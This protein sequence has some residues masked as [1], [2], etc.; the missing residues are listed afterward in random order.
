MKNYLHRVLGIYATRTA[1]ESASARL[2]E[3]GMLAENV[4]I[5]E[6]GSSSGG[7]DAKADSDDV[8]KEMLREGAIGTAVGTLAGAAGTIAMAAANVSLFVASPVVGALSMLGWGAALGGTV[9]ATVGAKR[10]KGEVADLVKDAL[11]NSHVVLVAHTAT[12]EETS[13]AQQIIGA[14]MAEPTGKPGA[15]SG[16]PVTS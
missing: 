1:A 10:S 8:L 7:D 13:Y 15:G 9:G 12:E 11:A 16:T 14:S 4:K 6:P 5:L 3:R 2:I